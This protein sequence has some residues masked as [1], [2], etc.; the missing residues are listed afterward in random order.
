MHACHQW[1]STSIVVR[2]YTYIQYILQYPDSWVRD[3]YNINVLP[4]ISTIDRDY[5]AI[6]NSW[7]GFMVIEMSEYILPLI[8]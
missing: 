6:G 7:H 1:P 3:Q 5:S 8:R 4:S 2:I